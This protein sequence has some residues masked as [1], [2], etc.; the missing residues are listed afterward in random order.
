MST[1]IPVTYIGRESPFVDRIYHSGMTFMPE[2][3][4]ELPDTI[5]VRFLRHEDVFKRGKSAEELAAE[6]EAAE[7]AAAQAAKDAAEKAQADLVAAEL[8]K[9]EALRAAQEAEAA[10]QAADAAAQAEAKAKETAT[11]DTAAKLAEADAEAKK[12][13]EAENARFDLMQQVDRM[14]KDSLRDMA[15]VNWGQTIHPNTGEAKV[16][17][18]VRGFIDQYGM[19]A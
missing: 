12:R 6:A 15:K 4:R 8:A 11:D 13:Q 16:R 14:D 18:M 5:A 7:A 10:R 1:T 19:P 3:T 17:D 2:Q 9:S